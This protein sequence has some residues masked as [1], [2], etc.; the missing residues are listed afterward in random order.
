MPKRIFAQ[1]ISPGAKAW[2]E[3]SEFAY[4][5]HVF[6]PVANLVNAESRVLSVVNPRVGNGPFSLVVPDTNFTDFIEAGSQIGSLTGLLQIGELQIDYSEAPLWAPAPDW[7]AAGPDSFPWTVDHLRAL[8]SQHADPDSFAQLVI[9][10]S[11][12][13]QPW[14][15]TL[16]A[17][18]QPASDLL[19]A[20]GQTDLQGIQDAAAGLAGLGVGLTPAG[21]DFL[22]GVMHGLYAV[23]GELNALTLCLN[24]AEAAIPRTNSLSAA[25]LEAA[26]RGEAGEPWHQLLAA[27]SAQDQAAFEA[28]VLRILP[29]GHTSGAD[30][31][32][33]F[34]AVLEGQ[35]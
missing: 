33:G 25:W 2:L 5:L 1:S 32:G 16:A 34:L 29:T 12:A 30:A 10:P 8:L 3:T 20:L 9:S 13:E 35:L 27:I 15:K 17:A 14:A 18:R 6:E 24:I 11:H 7:D 19:A 26:A 23:Y 28:A 4:V 31:L 21:D 22:V